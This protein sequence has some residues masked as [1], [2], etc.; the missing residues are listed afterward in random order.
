[1]CLPIFLI[2]HVTKKVGNMTSEGT[3]S[4]KRWVS[5]HE[6]GP[7]ISSVVVRRLMFLKLTVTFSDDF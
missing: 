5:L 4:G 2:S 3:A 1:M 6:V 7:N